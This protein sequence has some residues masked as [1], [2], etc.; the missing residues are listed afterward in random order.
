MISKRQ[1]FLFATL[2]AFVLVGCAASPGVNPRTARVVPGNAALLTGQTLQFTTNISTDPTKLIWSVNGTLGGDPTVGT[3]DTDGNYSAPALQ[4]ATPLSVT[5]T[6]SVRSDL[7]ASA[8]VTVVSPGQVTK[9]AQPQVAEYTIAPPVAASVSIQFGTDTTYGVSTWSQTAAG[10]GTPLSIFVAGMRA[11]SLYHMRAVLQ[12]PD[13]SQLDDVD[14]TFTTGSLPADVTPVITASLPNGMTPQPGVEMYDLLSADTP[15]VAT[16]TAGNIIWWYRPADGNPADSTQPVKLMPNGHFLLLW[17]PGSEVTL[18]G[19]PPTPNPLT[20]DVAREIDLTG[21]VVRQIDINT[22][23]SRLAAAGFNY[24]AARFHHDIT[25]LPNGHWIVIVNSVRQFTN[26]PGYSGTINVLGDAIIDLDTNL[27]PVWLWDE[28]DHLDVNRHP[29]LFPDWTHTN[30][31]LYSPTDGNLVVSIRHQNWLV[32][33]DYANGK[34]AG[35][36]IWRLGQGGDFTLQGGIDPTDWFYAQHGPSFTTQATAGKFGLAVFDNGDDRMYPNGET[37]AQSG[38]VTCPNYSSAQVL[39]IDETSKTASFVF[40]D[41]LA[42]YS[43]FG[44]NAEVL[45]NGHIEFDLCSDPSVGVAASSLYEV[46]PDSPPLTVLRITTPLLHGYRIY[47]LP[48]LY[49]GVQW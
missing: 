11:D 37:C 1:T 48:S 8:I 7:T 18:T 47:R 24:T 3:I 38:A 6:S 31:V 16:D 46:T 39:N 34:G 13:G 20:V 12:M 26:L 30:A 35:D 41:I 14:H 32:K 23:N 36:I 45:A 21:A 17:T 27:N 15:V 43:N 9:T 19:T 4:P 28:F 49:P 40:H 22:L 33:I 29:Y 44:G 25:V 5:A 42:N 10:A 2:F